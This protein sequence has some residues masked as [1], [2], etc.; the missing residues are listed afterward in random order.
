M[1]DR[2]IHFYCSRF[3]FLEKSLSVVQLPTFRSNLTK[4]SV[5]PALTPPYRVD[6]IPSMLVFLEGH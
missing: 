1:G 5:C 6:W 3:A 2:R 4:I